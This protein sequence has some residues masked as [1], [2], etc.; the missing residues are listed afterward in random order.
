MQ[1]ESSLQSKIVTIQPYAF[2]IPEDDR[3]ILDRIIFEERHM[4]YFPE[5]KLFQIQMILSEMILSEFFHT[6]STQKSKINTHPSSIEPTGDW[7]SRRATAGA[8]YHFPETFREARKVAR[9]GAGAPHTKE[10]G[11][12]PPLGMI[13]VIQGLDRQLSCGDDEAV[14]GLPTLQE[15]RRRARGLKQR[16]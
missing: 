6:W 11:L 2:A 8:P 4:G 9:G 14:Q 10:A 15:T 3:I 5:H 7:I 13:F 16:P 12:R 1:S